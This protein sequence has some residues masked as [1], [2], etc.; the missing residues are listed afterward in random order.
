MISEAEIDALRA[1][2][3]LVNTVDFGTFGQL[4]AGALPLKTAGR[5]GI[6]EADSQNSAALIMKCA[7]MATR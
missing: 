6:G 1:A 5:P 3:F 7:A 4:P 2:G